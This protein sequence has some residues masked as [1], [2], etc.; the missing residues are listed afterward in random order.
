MLGIISVSLFVPAQRQVVFEQLT[1]KDGLSNETINSI[2][3]DSKGF[4]W[5]CTDDGLNRYDGYTIKIFNAEISDKI[6]GQ[7]IQYYSLVEDKYKRIWIGSSKGLLILNQENDHLV[8]FM[9]FYGITLENK[10]MYGTINCLYYDSYDYLWVGTFA[11]L[12]K[13]N[14]GNPN[15]HEIKES[16]I[17]FLIKE[18]TD[19]L[20]ISNNTILSICED[21]QHQVWIT[22]NSNLLDCYNHEN[23]RI[24]HHLIGIPNLEKWES[25]SKI[26]RVDKNDDCWIS[27][28]GFGIIHWDRKKQK[29]SYFSSLTKDNVKIDIRLANRLM[30]DKNDRIWIGTDGN[31]VVVWNRKNGEIN[32]FKND[33]K[34]HTNLSSNS[35]Y[36]IY[37]DS[38]GIFWIGTYYAGINKLVSN[39]LDFGVQL[40]IPNTESSLSHNIVTG[41]CEDRKGEIWICTDGGG[42]NLFDKKTNSFKHFKNNPNDKSS[43]SINSTVALCCDNENNIWVGS[44]NGG[45]NRFDP[46]KQKFD[47]YWYNA[48]D[49]T[50]ISSNHP[51]G[52]ALDKSNNLW[53]ATVNKGLNLLKP[54]TSSF[55]RYPAKSNIDRNSP[56]L[57]SCPA[58]THLF[59]DKKNCLWIATENGLDMVN[60]NNVDFSLPVP[61][62]IF[63]HFFYIE[64]QNSLSDNHVSFVNEDNDGN[65]WI[66]TKGSGLNKLNPNTLE[67]TNY[68]TKDGLPHNIINGILVDKHNHLWI[69]T[70]NGLSNFDTTTK[71]FKNYNTSDG[72]QSNTFVKTSCLKTSDGMLLFGGI[73]GFNA[74]YPEKITSNTSN[75]KTVITDFRLFNQSVAI[76]EKIND[77]ILLPKAIY[78]MDELIL[79]YKE[80]DIS[81]EFSAMDYS[82]PDKNLFSYKMEGFDQNWQITDAR[83]RI[84]KYTNLD[85]GEYTFRVKASNNKDIWTEAETSIKVIVLPPWWMT[86]W[87]KTIS[88]FLII[89]LSASAFLLRIFALQKQKR[90]LETKVDEKTKQLQTANEELKKSNI[91]KDKFLSII[92]HDLINPFNTILGFSDLLLSNYSEWDDNSRITTIKTINNSSTEL[93]ELLGNLLQWSR[94]ERGLLE[95]SPEKIELNNCIL[96]IA[97]LLAITAKMK[98]INIHVNLSTE[99][100]LVKSDTQLL[101][102]ILRNLISNSIKFTPV[103]GQITI[104]TEISNNQIIVSVIDTG[105]GI[106][107]EKLENLFRIDIQHS[108]LGT[109]DE[110][111]TGLGLFLVKEFVT[112]QEGTLAIESE[113]G[114]GSTFSF[115]VPIW[116]EQSLDS[117]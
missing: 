35:I 56:N 47:H 80:N 60:L 76:G 102:A 18:S 39:K 1:T 98:E 66:G 93:Y 83:M 105:V 20:R 7:N 16:D 107:K 89:S 4:M 71:Q 26:V 21:Q 84:A 44:Y 17:Q 33:I 52:F 55:I 36:S 57:L 65:I 51:W 5:F 9:D 101:N 45:L 73:K 115:T 59:I 75:L 104:K 24:S 69:S 70:N 86:L 58:I 14:I 6:S 37:E 48:N 63:T 41:F 10:S 68:T 103:G 64:N 111:G 3:R 15:I 79:D 11:G 94:S 43:L 99:K 88:L 62:L 95:Y 27:I 114:K 96:K 78:E 100:C 32:H 112:K 92:A 2:F 19:P 67:F 50:S 106:S 49:S 12:S 113:V 40:S 53:I 30:I 46:K 42:L 72:L 116:H 28:N 22:S 82:N 85:P 117:Q 38:T 90:I 81:F 13:I 108:T 23:K 74:F 97:S 87:F 8:N 91:T 61:D 29:F 77:R 54:G 34:D 25:M 31:G 110:K 109:N